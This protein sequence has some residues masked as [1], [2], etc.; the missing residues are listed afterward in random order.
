MVSTIGKKIIFPCCIEMLLISNL[1]KLLFKKNFSLRS[2]N[3]Q[4][5]K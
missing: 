2:V 5:I 3:N 1:K 4:K